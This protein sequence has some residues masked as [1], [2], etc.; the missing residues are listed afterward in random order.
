MIGI[1]NLKQYF[2]MRRTGRTILGSM[3][4][5]LGLLAMYLVHHG[6]ILE[7]YIVLVIGTAVIAYMIIAMLIEDHETAREVYPEYFAGKAAEKA[8]ER[9]KKLNAAPRKPGN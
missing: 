6:W 7:M 4:L 9:A 3:G 1:S 8:I 2:R 5:M